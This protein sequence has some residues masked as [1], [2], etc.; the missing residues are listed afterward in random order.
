M[1]AASADEQV[2]FT[3]IALTFLFFCVGP[4]GFVPWKIAISGFY[5]RVEFHC[6]SS[7]EGKPVVFDDTCYFL[8]CQS[9]ND[10]WALTELLYSNYA[11]LFFSSLV[12]W[13]AKWLITTH[14]LSRL[15]LGVLAVDSGVEL[16]A[17]S[18]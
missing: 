17:L 4:Y 1:R 7:F 8:P 2:Q 9:Q 13:D 18:V 14:L 16:T 12:F 15:D 5:K 11:K 3:E 10:A 6:I